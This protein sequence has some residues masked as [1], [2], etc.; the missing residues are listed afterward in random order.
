MR[1]IETD[2]DIASLTLLRRERLRQGFRM[3]M[4]S[5][6][7]PLLGVFDYAAMETMNM[8]V[9]GRGGHDPGPRHGGFIPLRIQCFA[10][11]NGMVTICQNCP[12]VKSAEAASRLVTS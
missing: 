4:P 5:A 10:W 6:C 11:R 2:L 3:I 1:K 7:N 12:I 9:S 8:K